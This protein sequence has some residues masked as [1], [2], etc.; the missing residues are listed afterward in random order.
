[1]TFPD[2]KV[3]KKSGWTE[4]GAS[5][6][7]GEGTEYS[8]IFT[9]YCPVGT[10]QCSLSGQSWTKL[11]LHVACCP[12]QSLSLFLWASSS[13]LRGVSSNHSAHA[14]DWH[15]MGWTVEERK[16]CGSGIGQ[17]TGKIPL[18]SYSLHLLLLPKVYLPPA[19]WVHFVPTSRQPLC[20]AV[21][22]TCI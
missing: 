7:C 11:T 1:M 9:A 17:S 19:A 2:T 10:Q 15:R 12:S 18:P 8:L 4:A 20:I 13:L 3:K 22:Q 14:K 5:R 16:L 21:I 6:V